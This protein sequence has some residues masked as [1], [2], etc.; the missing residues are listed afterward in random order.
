VQDEQFFK[1]KEVDGEPNSETIICLHKRELS[2][3]SYLLEAITGKMHQLRVHMMA[4]G[5]PL[6]N[7]ALY[8]IAHAANSDDFTA[9]LKLLARSLA[10]KSPINGNHLFFESRR[11]LYD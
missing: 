9:P 10:F 3:T 6:L 1:M 7:D 8:P 4:L 2:H 5:L 11:S